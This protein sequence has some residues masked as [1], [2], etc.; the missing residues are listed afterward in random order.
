M[1]RGVVRFSF[2]LIMLWI[3]GSSVAADSTDFQI[4]NADEVIKSAEIGGLVSDTGALILRCERHLSVLDNGNTELAIY[5][6]GKVLDEKAASDYSQ[7]SLHY[8]S[9][10]EEMHLDF[11]RSIQADGVRMD[12]SKD[13]IQTRT[14]SHGLAKMYTDQKTLSFSI[15]ALRPGTAFEFLVRRKIKPIVDQEW[16]R[17]L[18]F[19]F[20]LYNSN[21]VPRVDPVLRSRLTVEI[22]Q[23]KSFN[24]FSCNTSVKPDIRKI[25]KKRSYT[26]ETAGALFRCCKSVDKDRL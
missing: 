25:E 3:L 1:T 15:P 12:A 18:P 13:A 6:C 2:I 5:V 19:N 4:P 20:V 10:F 26:W 8:N 16:V 22:P 17:Q 21:P 9:Y 24:Y 23:E 7:I 14:M 11:A